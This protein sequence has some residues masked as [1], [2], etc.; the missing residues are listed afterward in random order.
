MLTS[1]TNFGLSFNLFALELKNANYKL[2]KE[3]GGHLASTSPAYE[4]YFDVR[5][6]NA[7]TCSSFVGNLISSSDA[8]VTYDFVD[9]NLAFF[10]L[11][12]V[13]FVG[14]CHSTRIRSIGLAIG[15]QDQSNPSTSQEDS[16]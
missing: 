16:E 10:H 8:V 1:T 3:L 11:L 13:H 5:I 12:L 7:S 4:F 9:F 14:A 2:D 6:Q 15:L